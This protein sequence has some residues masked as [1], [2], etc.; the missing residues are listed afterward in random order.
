M[1]FDFRPSVCIQ[2]SSLPLTLSVL[3]AEAVERLCEVMR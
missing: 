3:S 1:I 2:Q